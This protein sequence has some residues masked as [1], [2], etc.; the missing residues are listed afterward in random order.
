L[1]IPD[2]SEIANVCYCECPGSSRR[3]I[4]ILVVFM[5]ESCAFHPATG[6]AI[7]EVRTTNKEMVIQRKSLSDNYNLLG[8]VQYKLC[9]DLLLIR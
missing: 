8:L 9:I 4:K 3:K 5:L 1:G 6:L 2:K 7:N